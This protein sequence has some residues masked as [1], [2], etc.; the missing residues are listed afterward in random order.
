MPKMNLA[1]TGS[2]NIVSAF[3]WQSAGNLNPETLLLPRE[4]DHPDSAY[5]RRQRRQSSS[6]TS[7]KKADPAASRNTSSCGIGDTG[8]FPASS[9]WNSRIFL[10]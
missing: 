4:A 6:A 3:S 7:K 8:Q 5:L 10:L 2:C 1:A 9:R